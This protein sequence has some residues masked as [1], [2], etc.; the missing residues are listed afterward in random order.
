MRLHSQWILAVFVGPLWIAAPAFAQLEDADLDGVEDELDNCLLVYN[1]DQV[2][3]NGSGLGDSCDSESAQRP[4]PEALSSPSSPGSSLG[5]VTPPPS[6]VS[7][8]P[9]DESFGQTT[10][11]IVGPNDGR[12]RGPIHSTGFVG[13][14]LSFDGID[15]SVSHALDPSLDI[16]DEITLDAWIFPTA[17]KT[18]W[19]IRKGGGFV[20]YGLFLTGTNDLGFIVGVGGVPPQARSSG[21]PINTWFHMAGTYDGNTMKLYVDGALVSTVSISGPIDVRRDA[22]LLI[23]TRLSIPS[24]TFQGLI[25]EVEIFDRALSQSEIQGIFNAGSH[26]KCKALQVDLDVKPGS[27]PNSINPSLEGDLP[28]AILGSDSFDVE[29]VDVNTLAFGPGGAPFDH[30]HGPHFEDVNGDGFTDLTVHFRIEETGIEFGDMEACITGETLAGLSFQGCDDI[31][32]VP[33][34]DGDGLLDAEEAAIG[35]DALN[36][37]TDGDGFDD[38]EEVLVMG[39]DPLDPLDPTPDPVPEPASWLMLVAGAAFLGLLYRRRVR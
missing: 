12:L 14:A 5:C 29:D 1:P 20:P 31:R 37:D 27:D 19:V 7:W 33:D 32:T 11:D 24:N 26:G 9:L 25:D 4:L 38:G 39:T 16:T 21:Y 17:I 22:D 30:S 23:G 13:N 15:D 6:L 3:T 2:D 34:M 35:T 10:T 28:V 36:P 8:W 18:Q